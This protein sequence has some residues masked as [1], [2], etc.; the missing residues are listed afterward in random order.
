VTTLGILQRIFSTVELDF[1]QWA[2]C[3][4]IALSLLVVEELIK[5]F[6]RRGASASD[7]TTAQPAMVV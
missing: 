6:L 1:N 4:R 2:T 3:A 5:L 7:K